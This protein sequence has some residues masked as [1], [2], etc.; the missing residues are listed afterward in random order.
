MRGPAYDRIRTET[1]TLDADMTP[2]DIADT[3]KR[4]HFLAAR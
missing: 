3:L 4:L 1:S 2:G